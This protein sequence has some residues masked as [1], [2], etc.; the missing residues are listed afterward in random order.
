MFS[1]PTAGKT[2][3]GIIIPAIFPGSGETAQD[4]LYQ[5]NFP[6][7]AGKFTQYVL[8]RQIF[9][10]EAGKFAFLYNLKNIE[11]QIIRFG[12]IPQDRV[13]GRLPSC[14]DLPQ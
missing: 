11:L 10:A 9:P 12:N 2:A 13:V 14:F 7:E 8:Y 4:V 6:A 1:L 5:Q 3:H